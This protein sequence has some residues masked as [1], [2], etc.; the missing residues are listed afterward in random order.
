MGATAIEDKLQDEVPQTIANMLDAGMSMWVLTGDKLETAVNIGA[1]Q[2][3]ISARLN[4]LGI[5]LLTI[6]DS[7]SPH[8]EPL[9]GSLLMVTRNQRID[10]RL[11]RVLLGSKTDHLL[12]HAWVL[13]SP[14]CLI[15]FRIET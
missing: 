1:F 12:S 8:W 2:S 6:S 11:L 15:S 13:I 9:V 3:R 5:V 10:L 4:R 14:L 7:R